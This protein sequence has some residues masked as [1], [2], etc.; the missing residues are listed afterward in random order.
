MESPVRKVCQNLGWIWIKCCDFFPMREV[1]LVGSQIKMF[2]EDDI[3]QIK[4][5][6][7]PFLNGPATPENECYYAENYWITITK[8]PI[9]CVVCSSLLLTKEEKIITEQ[10]F[11]FGGIQSS[12]EYLNKIF[13]NIWN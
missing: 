12:F 2:N 13:G 11:R 1:G 8:L 5:K 10:L 7:Y 4:L 9:N 3:L 6:Q